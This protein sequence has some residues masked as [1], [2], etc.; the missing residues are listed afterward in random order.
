MKFEFWT[1]F[2]FWVLMKFVFW[3]YFEFV[4][5]SNIE[6]FHVWINFE[7][8]KNNFEQISSLN[9][10]L[11][12]NLNIYEKNFVQNFKFK[13]LRKYFKQFVKFDKSSKN[14]QANEKS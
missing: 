13:H 2:E 11:I 1:K 12:L 5:Y 14:S 3:P 6:K 9:K 10:I 4:K 7:F 8:K